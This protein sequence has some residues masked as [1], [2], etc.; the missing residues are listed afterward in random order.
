MCT[1]LD[2]RMFQK[3]SDGSWNGELDDWNQPIDD[4]VWSDVC[5]GFVTLDGAH[6]D[7]GVVLTPSFE[8]DTTATAV[9]RA[10]RPKR[11]VV[12]DRGPVDEEW[13]RKIETG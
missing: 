13:L 5:N 11:P 2:D 12:F 1:I 10:R 6:E 9:L 8:L 7:Y 4:D 3:F